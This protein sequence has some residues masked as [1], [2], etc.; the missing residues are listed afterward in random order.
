MNARPYTVQFTTLTQTPYLREGKGRE[1][2]A[3]GFANKKAILT[4]LAQQ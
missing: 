4:I 2:K 1:N 3:S